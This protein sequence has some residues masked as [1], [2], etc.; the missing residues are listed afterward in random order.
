MGSTTKAWALKRTRFLTDV[1]SLHQYSVHQIFLKNSRRHEGEQDKDLCAE[2][3]CDRTARDLRQ[4]EGGLV[5]TATFI[6]GLICTS[7]RP[8][9]PTALDSLIYDSPLH[10]MYFS[11][12]NLC[13]IFSRNNHSLPNC[14][15]HSS[16]R[17][18]TVPKGLPWRWTIPESFSSC[19]CFIHL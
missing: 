1:T 7:E 10:H 3:N 2:F 17:L 6:R 15:D 18:G 5:S 14:I 13:C 9:F 16:C 11:C 4:M 12:H 19:E 8:F